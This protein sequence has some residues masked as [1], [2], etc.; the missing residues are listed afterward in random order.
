M[1][2]IIPLQGIGYC[3]V[4]TNINEEIDMEKLDWE[5][6]KEAMGCF[7]SNGGMKNSM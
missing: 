7:V 2:T 1:G 3:V 5:S 6:N 4:C